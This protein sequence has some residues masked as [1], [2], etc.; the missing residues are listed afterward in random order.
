M[1]VLAY[2]SLTETTLVD[3][4]A[5]AAALTALEASQVADLPCLLVP[6]R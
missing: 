2:D 6:G 1:G 5:M 3:G 4:P